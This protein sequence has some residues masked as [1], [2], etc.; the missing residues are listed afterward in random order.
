MASLPVCSCATVR[1]R[2]KRFAT[3]G[4]YVSR[5]LKGERPAE[6][7]VIQPTT[8]ELFFNVKTAKPLGLELPPTLLARADEV[9]ER[10]RRAAVDGNAALCGIIVARAWGN[11]SL[12]E[13]TGIRPF[14]GEPALVMVASKIGESRLLREQCALSTP[15][16]GRVVSTR[17]PQ[18]GA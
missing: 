7:P 2:P 15:L 16:L 11:A 14:K 4:I 1:I 9:I 18:Q 8:Y 12:V 10:K 3:P 13:P 6:L 17:F 5:I